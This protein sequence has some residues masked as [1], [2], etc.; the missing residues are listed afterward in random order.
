LSIQSNLH[1]AI[2][3]VTMINKIIPISYEGY[4]GTATSET[5]FFKDSPEIVIKKR[6]LVLICPGGGYEFLSDREGE[7]IAFQFNSFGYHAAV[8]NY[9]VAPVTYPTQ[10]LEVSAAVKYF[11]DHAEEYHIDPDRI[12][13][14]GASAGAH[15]AADYA[16]GYF[17]EE[18]SSVLKVTPDYLRPSG[19]ILAY[20]VITSGEF[21]HRGSFDNLLGPDKNNE[22]MLAYLSIENRITKETPPAFIWHTFPDGCVPM[23]NSLLLAESMRQENIPFELHIF[24]SGDHGLGL[25]S[26]IT[27]SPW[28][29]EINAGASQWVD[30]CHTWLKE[31]FGSLCR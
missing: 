24:P 14:Y 18:V 7:S 3:G 10:L 21:A 28:G 11:K 1:H 19:M 27:R 29:N 26:E 25:A 23:E 20:P 16:T 4:N 6:P 2:R 31:L 9:S 12:A 13:I 15:A 5:F 30:L 22:E 8:I 17:R